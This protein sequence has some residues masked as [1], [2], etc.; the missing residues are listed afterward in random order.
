MSTELTTEER[1]KLALE[2]EGLKIEEKRIETRLKEVKEVLAPT[3][4]DDEK[5]N[6]R[7]GVIELKKRDKWTY[8]PPT[9]QMA[10]DLKTKQQEEVAKGEATN[11]PTFYIEYRVK[12][13][14]VSE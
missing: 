5:L 2:Y 6:C 9:Q 1:E 11:T 13:K 3:V 8:T 14:N 12:D 7:Y 10:E 4:G